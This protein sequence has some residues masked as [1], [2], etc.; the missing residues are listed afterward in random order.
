MEQDDE[1]SNEKVFQRSKRRKFNEINEEIEISLSPHHNFN[2]DVNDAIV[3]TPITN[4]N[5][6]TIPLPFDKILSEE[7]NMSI[8]KILDQLH[9]NESN[10]IKGF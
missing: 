5:H 6:N 2:N 7:F 4:S 3:D 8:S 9:N 10:I 1:L